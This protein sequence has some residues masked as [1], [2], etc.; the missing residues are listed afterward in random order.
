MSMCS[1]DGRLPAEVLHHLASFLSNLK[2]FL[3]ADIEMLEKEVDYVFASVANLRIIADP[4]LRQHVF[5]PDRDGRSWSPVVG[6][7][8]RIDVSKKH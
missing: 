4:H 7:S 3:D 2:V 1:V 5:W 8:K 6:F